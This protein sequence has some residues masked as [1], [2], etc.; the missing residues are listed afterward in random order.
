VWVPED[1]ETF[2]HILQ[3]IQK[4][5]PALIDQE[6]IV[7]HSNNDGLPKLL[8]FTSFSLPFN[9]LMRMFRMGASR[10]FFAQLLMVVLQ[11]TADSKSNDRVM[12]CPLAE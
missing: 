7:I 8:S 4:T 10:L 11:I 1:C 12:S 2:E 3:Q 5:C 6:Q 9:S